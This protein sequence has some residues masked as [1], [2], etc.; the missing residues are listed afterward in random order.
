[1]KDC[2]FT[3]NWADM[4]AGMTNFY[5]STVITHCT[6]SKN[7]GDHEG[8]GICNDDSSLMLTDCIFAE[9]RSGETGGGMCNEQSSTTLINCTFSGNITTA[10]G[11]G[12]GGGIANRNN[13]SLTV[14]NCTFN[15]NRAALGGA[16]IY[17][18]IRSSATLTNCAFN[19]NTAVNVGGGSGIYNWGSATIT[20]CTLTN[21]KYAGIMNCS[22]LLSVTNC[23]FSNNWVGILDIAGPSNVTNGVFWNNQNVGIEWSGS[24]PEVTYSNVQSGWPGAGNIN[25]DPMFVDAANGD[26]HLLPDSPCIDAGNNAALPSDTT[27]LDGD[28]DIEESIPLDLDGNPRIVGVAVDMGAYEFLVPIIEVAVDIKPG[29]YPNAINL[30]SYGLVPVAILSSEQFNATTVNPDTVE[31]GGAGV[32]VRGKS[33]KFMAH[34]EDVNGDGLVDLV[35][36]VASQNLDPG[37]FQDGYGIL[38]GITYDGKAIQGKD[39]VIIVPSEQ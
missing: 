19:N 7:W 15:D 39:E 20:N 8:G 11:E 28:G 30:G 29:S 26:Y 14:V 10:S 6:F 12:T 3:N 9:N 13:S 35:L 37:A 4:G 1:V 22:D 36:Q 27:D 16:G 31:L 25:A 23:T 38:T 24:M 17:N 5:S 34:E 2:T 18:Q 32:E 33:N 21:N